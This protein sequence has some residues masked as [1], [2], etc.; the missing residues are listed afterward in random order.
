[1]KFECDIISLNISYMNVHVLR[2]LRYD[3][4]KLNAGVILFGVSSIRKNGISSFKLC[5]RFAFG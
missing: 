5:F 1:M 3:D 4:P 2:V